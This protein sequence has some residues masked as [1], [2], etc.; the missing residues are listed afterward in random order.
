MSSRS[1]T[2]RHGLEITNDVRAGMDDLGVCTIDHG[3]IFGDGSDEVR[4]ASDALDDR[5]LDEKID[6][7]AE[8][9]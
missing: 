2:D 3:V 9:K 1:C 8:E 5:T 4:H 7:R 6:R